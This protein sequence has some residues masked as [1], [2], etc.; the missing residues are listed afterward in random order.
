MS[1]YW[2]KTIRGSIERAVR[3]AG[4]RPVS[5]PE[6]PLISRYNAAR[7]TI[8]SVESCVIDITGSDRDLIFD[9]GLAFALH[10]NPL[11]VYD[12]TRG[13]LISDWLGHSAADY[14]DDEELGDKIKRYLL[15]V[16]GSR[17]GSPK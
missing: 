3:E 8:E 10:R 1:M 4:W 16:E 14:R 7:T 12:A 13:S 6:I 17:H 9:L 11:A 2:N 15:D 5:F